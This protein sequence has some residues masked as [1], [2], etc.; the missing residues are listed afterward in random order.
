MICEV[1]RIERFKSLIAA[2]VNKSSYYILLKTL[3]G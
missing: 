1:E 3:L 2:I